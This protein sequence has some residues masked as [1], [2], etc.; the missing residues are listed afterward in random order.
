MD[1]TARDLVIENIKSRRSVRNFQEKSVPDDVIEKI[2]EAGRFA[3]SA[4]NR[5]PWKFIVVGSAEVKKELYIAARARLKK[6]YKLIPVLKF[7]KKDLRDERVVNAIKK[8]AESSEDTVF[9][10]APLLIFIANDTRYG[11]TKAD[12]CLAAQNMM[13][14]AH[15]LGVGSC[16]IGRGKAIPKKLLQKRFTLPAYYDFNVYMAFGYPEGLKR[17]PPA[18]R[19]DT[20]KRI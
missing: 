15:S 19:E 4:L 17:T 2:V 16:F 10:N 18:R 11:D 5:Q 1:G 3:P 8:T 14:A 6:L 7:L 9:Y 13:L 12:C 20:V